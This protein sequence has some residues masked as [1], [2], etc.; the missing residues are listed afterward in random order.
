[1]TN[2]NAWTKDQ[3]EAFM[4]NV[5]WRYMPEGSTHI[6]VND[7]T[8][9]K[10]LKLDGGI[11]YYYQ[12]P[13]FVAL[14]GGADLSF[15][16]R[17]PCQY[18]K[19][20]PRLEDV[21][22]EKEV[23]SKSPVCTENKVT[24]TLESLLEQRPEKEMSEALNATNAKPAVSDEPL[25]WSGEGRPPVGE[26]L[27][28]AKEVG[29]DGVITWFN[30]PRCQVVAH[31][32]NG[33][34]FFIEYLTDNKHL[35]TFNVGDDDPQYRKIRT[36]EDIAVEEMMKVAPEVVGGEDCDSYNERFARAIYRAGLPQAG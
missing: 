26:Y 32:M 35:A 8:D 18:L 19:N 33:E 9:E 17:I 27:D 12:S 4:L 34:T 31:H 30:E 5:D 16:L 15:F 2:T 14:G 23:V 25:G 10:W 11:W 24:K 3:K 13:C 20:K 1:M 7:D 6:D 28:C 21:F 36:E 29:C 22:K